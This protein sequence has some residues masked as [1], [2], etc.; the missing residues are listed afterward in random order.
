MVLEGDQWPLVTC[1]IAWQPDFALSRIHDQARTVLSPHQFG[2]GQE[3]GCAQIVQSV[4]HLLRQKPSVVGSPLAVSEPHTLRPM[5]CLSIDMANAFN[6]IN[7]AKVLEAVY[8]DTRLRACWR[9]VEFGYGEPSLLLMRCNDSVPDAETFIRSENGV[10]QGDP[11]AAFLFSLAMH[12]VYEHIARLVRAGCYAYVDDG[13]GVGTLEECYKVWQALPALL[14]PFGLSLNAAK[15]EITCFY[16]EN[17]HNEQD[18]IALQAFRDAG[19]TFNSKSLCLLGCVVAIDDAEVAHVLRTSDKFRHGRQVPFR[20]LRRLHKQT[21]MISLRHLN[22]TVLTH[23]LRAMAPAATLAHAATYDRMVLEAAHEIV[24]ITRADG[25]KYD[26]Q[27]RWSLADGGLGLTA[28]TV[29][30]AAAYL[31]GVE[32]TLR[33]SPAFASVW[34]GNDILDPSSST[35]VAIDD[36]LARIRTVI[37]GLSAIIAASEPEKK[38]K[39]HMKGHQPPDL[40]LP[41]SASE[42]VAHFR[43]TPSFNIQSSVVHRISTLSINARIIQA[44]MRKG[45]G[46]QELARIKALRAKESSLW[47]RTL[48]TEPGLRLRDDKWQWAARLR[49]G[50]PVPVPAPEHLGCNHVEVFQYDTWHA[51]G[52]VAGAHSRAITAR[53]NAVVNTI[54]RHARLL[55]LDPCLE[56]TQLVDDSDERPDVEIPMPDDTTLLG[57]VTISHP[58]S[59]SACQSVVARNV[60]AIGGKRA[61][62]K[63]KKYKRAADAHRMEFNAIVLY[64]HGGFHASALRFIKRLGTA[65]DQATSLYS[66]TEWK[67]SLKAHMAM[68][69]QRGSADIIVRHCHRGRSAASHHMRQMYRV[70]QQ[71]IREKLA[72]KAGN[73][74]ST[75]AL[76]WIRQG[77]RVHAVSDQFDPALDWTDDEVPEVEETNTSSECTEDE[78]DLISDGSNN[79]DANMDVGRAEVSDSVATPPNSVLNDCVPVGPESDRQVV[80]AIDCT[81]ANDVNATTAADNS[82]C[83]LS[84]DVDCTGESCRESNMNVID[85]ATTMMVDVSRISVISDN[86]PPLVHNTT[87]YTTAY[88]CRQDDGVVERMV[89]ESADECGS[90]C[91]DVVENPV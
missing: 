62:A 54:A 9:A 76:P 80:E 30:A 11:L 38:K 53:H 83:V 5:A 33:C 1:F 65:H 10:R 21:G 81:L 50:M 22:G 55:L 44:G 88:E 42:F 18:V 8:A 71:R 12:P 86:P 91:G 36:A 16:T 4:Q 82:P 20:R 74:T 39:K 32:C 13:H 37:S 6:S 27:L 25:N 3:D 41:D 87:L 61:S 31:A 40:L 17:L 59:K 56:P 72:R 78:K 48:P 57:D 51:I 90:E 28:A 75:V 2:V 89:M 19:V 73:G 68:A 49:L 69:V 34:A 15:C 67:D 66:L 77:V 47:L 84:L 70:R 64:T 52:C 7:R 29:L 35:Y 63:N 58:T 26:E 79:D 23:Q 46:L 43:T 85:G 45:E 14:E 60:N 24:G